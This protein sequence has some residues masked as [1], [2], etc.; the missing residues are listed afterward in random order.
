MSVNFTLTRKVT[1]H[2]DVITHEVRPNTAASKIL[3]SRHVTRRHPVCQN[4][5]V[6]RETTGSQR[7]QLVAA[8]AHGT[9]R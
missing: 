9:R 3:F 6:D 2:L 1:A 5:F 8:H 7:M 4:V